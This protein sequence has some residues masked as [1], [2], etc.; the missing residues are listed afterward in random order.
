MGSNQLKS[1]S[2]GKVEGFEIKINNINELDLKDKIIE[3]QRI[4]IPFF[5]KAPL[6]MLSN[7][8]YVTGN[9]PHHEGLILK[10]EKGDYYVAQT[11]PITFEKVK[12][13]DTAVNR[14]TYFCNL[15]K[16]S[17]NNKIR[18]IWVPEKKSFSVNAI[19]LFIESLPDKYDLIQENCQYFCKEILEAFPLRKLEDEHLSFFIKG[20][21]T[22]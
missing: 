10:S 6:Q 13:Y 18:D 16:Y 3:V 17:K 20:T 5:D 11:Y 2:I 7:V 19:K 21:S 22:E 4:R 14:I 12:D 8:V 9:S 15:N 1:G